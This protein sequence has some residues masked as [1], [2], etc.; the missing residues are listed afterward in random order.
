MKIATIKP[1]NIPPRKSELA[2]DSGGGN[3]WSEQ[4][5]FASPKHEGTFD[6]TVIVTATLDKQSLENSLRE[7][8]VN[9]P[10]AGGVAKSIVQSPSASRELIATSTASTAVAEANI[11]GSPQAGGTFGQVDGV[12]DKATLTERVENQNLNGE[13]DQLKSNTHSG[14]AGR[15]Y[16]PEGED[17]D[18]AKKR[19]FELHFYDVIAFEGFRC[20]QGDHLQSAVFWGTRS[21]SRGTS[22]LILRLST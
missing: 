4:G 22:N 20:M 1:Y 8:D 6:G 10:G 3:G 13:N 19:E 21:Y 15:V 12:A 16:D 11:G 9:G 5:P 7:R 14:G 17:D 2:R 18:R